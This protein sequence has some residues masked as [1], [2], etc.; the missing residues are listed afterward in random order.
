MKD[1]DRQAFAVQ[2]AGLAETYRQPVSEIAAEIYFRALVGFELDEI[3]G[4]V[5]M[6][7]GMSKWFPR[8]SEVIE[9]I[10]ELRRTRRVALEQARRAELALPAESPEVVSEAKQKFAELVDRV[11]RKLGAAPR[12][13]RR[14]LREMESDVQQLRAIDASDEGQRARVEAAVA[15]YREAFGSELANVRPL[16]RRGGA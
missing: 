7:V 3:A 6:H 14:S 11:A 1:E 13:P 8:P 10:G 4:A 2:L 12:A 5:A 9:C 15:R 16:R